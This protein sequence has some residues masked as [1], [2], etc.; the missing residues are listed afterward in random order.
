MK[1]VLIILG[2]LFGLALLGVLIEWIKENAALFMM[3]LFSVLGFIFFLSPLFFICDASAWAIFF[4]M[5]FLYRNHSNKHPNNL[6]KTYFEETMDKATEQSSENPSLDMSSEIPDE[7]KESLI[8]CDIILKSIKL[9]NKNIPSLDMTN[10]INET[11]R[12]LKELIDAVIDDPI[13]GKKL[14]RFS[15]YYLPITEKLLF[16]YENLEKASNNSSTIKIRN[17]IEQGIET[18]NKGIE[19]YLIQ[20]REYKNF[21]VQSDVDVMTQLMEQD[22]LI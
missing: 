18:L 16:H 6:S 15:D 9:H 4:L 5:K 19:N 13:N 21:D 3:I 22:G 14:S 12:L 7:T 1:I 10:K 11:E 2:V 8:K 20:L 17:D